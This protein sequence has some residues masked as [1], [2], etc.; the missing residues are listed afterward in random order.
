MKN[1]L[2]LSLALSTGIGFSQETVSYKKCYAPDYIEYQEQKTPGFKQDLVEQF[3]IAQNSH[4]PK[5]NTPYVIPVVVHIVY[6][7]SAQNL[8]DSI[9]HNQIK[10][11][12][13]DFQRRNADTVTCGVILKSVVEG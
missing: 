5:S 13:E 9:V 12:N 11:L 2:L 8:H 1:I 4:L 7:T 10:T 3:E 6:N